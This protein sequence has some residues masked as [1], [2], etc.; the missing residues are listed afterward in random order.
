MSTGTTCFRG[1]LICALVVAFSLT[2]HT[3]YAAG[4]GTVK[5]VVVDKATGE[6]LVGANVVVLNTS[7]GSAADIDGLITIYNVPEGQQ[8]LKIS[9]IGYQTITEEVKVSENSVIQKE[10]R[11]SP[12]AIQGQE[13][14]VTAQASGQNGAINQQLTSA[15]IENVVSAARIQELP[16]ANAAES[17][18][19]LPGVSLIRSGG[20]A[21]QIVI[22]G[23]SPQYNMITIDGV[24][25][26]PTNSGDRGT[27]LS[28]ISSNMVEGIEVSKTV[29]PDMDAAVLGGTVN[30]DIKEAKAS[31]TDVPLVSLLVQGG[32][33]NIISSYNNYKYVASVEDRYFDDRLGIFA[34]G[35]VDRSNHTSD[36]LGGTYYQ[37]D[38]VLH[39]DVV[40]LGSL[41]LYFYP[42]DQTRYNGTLVLDY[43]LPDGKIALT[44][45]ISQ[46]KTNTQYYRE[47]YDLQNYGNDIQYEVQNSHNILNVITN[48][49][50][51]EQT[52]Y[53]TKIKVTLSH[54][55]SENVSP[56]NWW[57]SF[58]QTS[59]GVGNINPKLSPEAIASASAPLVNFNN[60]TFR[61]NSTWD[62]FNKQRNLGGSIDLERGVNFSD[63]VTVTFKAGGSFKYTDRY[64]NYDGGSGNIFGSFPITNQVRQL[65]IQ[66][67]PWMAQPPYNLNPNGTQELPISMF[68]LPGMKFGNYLNGNYSMNNA[69][70]IGLISSVMDNIVGFG[71]AIKTSGSGGVNPYIPDVLG[72]LDN[73]YNGLERR[74]AGYAMASANVGT[75]ISIIGGVRYQ[76]LAT[77]YTAAHF[78]NASATNPYP[79]TLAHTD[80]TVYEYH[81]YLLPDVILKYNPLSWLNARLAY[82]N[83]LSY[84]AFNTIIPILDVYSTSITW[85]NYALKPA[86]S[87]NYDLQLS[88]YNNNIGLLTAGGFIKDI[89]N[90]IFSQSSFISNSSAYPG[91]PSNSTGKSINTFINDPFQVTVKGIEGEWQTHFWYLPNPLNGLVLNVNYSHIFSN[92]DYPYVNTIVPPPNYIPVH[93][94]TFYVDQLINQPK[95]IVNL[96]VGYD[97]RKFSVLVSMIYQASVYN[98]TNFYNSMRSDKAKYVRWDISAKQG[99]PW[100]GVELYVDVN[101]L[102]SEND[103]YLIRGSGFP[104]SEQDYGLTADIGLRWK[105][106]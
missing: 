14:V 17:I 71:K 64:Y 6:P 93:V 29:T 37:Q 35:I 99:L 49:L 54:S 70:N 96:S 65:I 97:Y 13:V 82:T 33:N 26:P 44:N 59:A 31:S 56:D 53:S 21:T 7:L 42:R 75:D 48:I 81:G 77:S 103:V 30:F 41:D 1:S 5:G 84:P 69:A 3:S 52:L 18:G 39:P 73:D 43:K 92:A 90:L 27:D 98:T 46:E 60:M 80:S 40:S 91:I 22:R 95:D 2:F 61:Y 72:S 94:D 32:Y 20:E 34:Q 106:L 83:T 15:N 67:N 12:Q 16:D 19:R 38:K 28:M 58:D 11:L 57:M 66:Q 10:F 62:S 47:T 76:G 74:D 63:L 87:K 51:Y 105:L 8:T 102:N 9:Y 4:F 79:N 36:E 85:N 89:D 24:E 55:Y 23:L 78:L 25:I 101:N 88:V 100:F 86:Q 50:N 45:L 68:L 104:T